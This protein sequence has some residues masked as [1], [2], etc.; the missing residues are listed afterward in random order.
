MKVRDKVISFFALF[1]CFPSGGLAVKK[2]VVLRKTVEG[3]LTYHLLD[4]SR[5]MDLGIVPDIGNFAYEFKVKGRDVLIPPKSFKS[6]LE[7]H[8]FCCGIP[9]LAPFANRIDKDY[10]FFQ[11][12]KYLLNDDLGNLLRTPDTKLI[13]HGLLVFDRRWKVIN[14]GAS[15][16]DGAFITSRLEFYRYPDL[17]AQ[18]P[19]SH[20]LEVTYR[21]KDGKAENT[22][23]ISNLGASAMPVDVGYHPYFL[24][25]GPRE[26]W[27]LSLAAKIHWLPND[28]TQLIPTGEKEPTNKYLPNAKNFTLGNTFI[29][30]NFSDLERDSK[31]LGHIWV[32][33]KS[34]RV[35]VVYG[36]E[37]DF[38]V[39]YAP[40]KDKGTL[41]CI[42]PQTGPTNAFNLNHEEKFP[43][44]LVLEPGKVFKAS[45][46]IVPTGF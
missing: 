17:I 3:H 12:K 32:K 41:I 21:L 29:D 36:K 6:Y 22:T 9:F 18:F 8:W 16:A 10:Y 25:D 1:F 45:F 39:V 33:G 23:V 20:V 15:D 5:N 31:G 14:T 28:H 38:A 42:E 44:L 7:A 37:Y 46:W 35:E 26:S 40:L 24:P 11:N 2:Y 27:T 30:D 43:S 13:I 4:Y 19:F 34:E